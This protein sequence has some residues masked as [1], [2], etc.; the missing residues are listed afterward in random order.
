[1]VK[2]KLYKIYFFTPKTLSLCFVGTVLQMLLRMR[3]CSC[4]CCSGC[5]WWACVCTHHFTPSHAKL[6]LR[7]RFELSQSHY[8][9]PVIY[10]KL[11]NT[12]AHRPDLDVFQICHICRDLKAHRC[13]INAGSPLMKTSSTRQCDQHESCAASVLTRV[14]FQSIPKFS[15]N[16]LRTKPH[17]NS[18][19]WLKLQRWLLCCAMTT[20]P[21]S[22]SLPYCT[23]THIHKSHAVGTHRH[24]NRQIGVARWQ[25][26]CDCHLSSD[27]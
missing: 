24:M 27:E 25:C 1:M 23:H 17:D 2:K 12:T 4:R 9:A 5:C 26:L 6:L 3:L 15:W 22:F 21:L 20:H 11:V 16:R 8:W 10:G 14:C 13:K 7:K 19:I 18:N